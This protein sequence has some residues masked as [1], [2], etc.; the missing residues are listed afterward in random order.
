MNI[1]RAGSRPSLTP[2]PDYFT[3]QVRMDPINAIPEPGRVRAVQVTFEPGARTAWH[4]HPYGQTLVVTAGKGLVQ[5][6]G[7][8]IH[9][10][11][12]GDVVSIPA[13][14]KHW[15]GASP[16]VGMSHIAI[17]EADAD[18]ATSTWLEHVTDAEYGADRA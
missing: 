9:E 7:E 18:G 1:H 5:Q 3:G 17:Q 8:A 16:D 10:I 12:P 4:H 6:E 2:S 11:T 15:H 13:G 14:E